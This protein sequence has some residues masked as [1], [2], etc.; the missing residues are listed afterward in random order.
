MAGLKPAAAS[1][2]RS[3]KSG[4]QFGQNGALR[5]QRPFSFAGPPMKIEPYSDAY[6]R[7]LCEVWYD[8]FE[9]AGLSHSPETTV[10]SLMERLAQEIA[11]GWR[12]VLAVDAS[13]LAGF[14]AYDPEKAYLNQLFLT[15]RAQGRGIGKALLD[16][17]KEKM[18]NGFR[19]RTHTDNVGAQRFYER[20]GL[21][22]DATV[23]HPRYGHLT[24]I[25][26]WR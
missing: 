4:S 15:R 23:Q 24:H 13:G 20:E 22:R 26:K 3:A 19:L 7:A 11:G 6:R 17:A 16:F 18:P 8:S 2:S 5:W 14:L 21:V 10:E 1:S 9:S 12:V 25:Y